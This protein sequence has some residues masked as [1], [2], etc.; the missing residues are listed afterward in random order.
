MAQAQ[1]PQR[2]T[3]RLRG[4]PPEYFTGNRSK[5]DQFKL[6]FQVYQGLNDNHTIMVTPYL[7]TLLAISLCKGSNITDWAKEQLNLLNEKVDRQN[8]P[9]PK[10][11]NVL[12]T[13]FT[14]ALDSAYADITKREKAYEAISTLNMDSGID[15]DTYIA[16][17]K[18]LANKAGFDLAASA[19]VQ[20]FVTGLSS[21]LRRAIHKRDA[22]C[23]TM[24]QYI[25]AAQTEEK[26]IA[27]D[28][29]YDGK[30]K[31]KYAW[32]QPAAHHHSNGRRANGHGHHRRHPNDESVPMDVDP[33]VFTQ[34]RRATTDA[35]VQRYKI[36][37][38]CFRCDKQGH[39]ARDCPM[40][41]E[42][43]FKPSFGKS[44]KPKQSYPNKKPQPQRA[45]GFRKR[46][47]PHG[48]AQARA[49]T[50]EEVEDDESDY[51]EDDVTDLA[52]RTTRLSDDQRGN[53]LAEL[54]KGNTDF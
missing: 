6:E 14:A 45:G 50:I 47:K 2:E 23:N 7:R 26:K 39:M 43:P 8:N 13:D 53:L 36:E 28:E 27:K 1:A 40:R 46:N 16:T 17:F 34:I 24:Q 51:E 22:E 37:G 15:L 35:E 9:I 29:Y 30:K 52:A 42:Q 41:K 31:P 25:D 11:D 20:L 18:N 38:R 33:P 10:T 44:R 12:W 4:D 3:G 19:T 48:Y 32:I 21:K 5:L 54:I 49:A